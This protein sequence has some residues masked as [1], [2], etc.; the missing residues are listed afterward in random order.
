MAVSEWVRLFLY[1]IVWKFD[2]GVIPKKE[3]D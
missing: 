2:Y 1:C 3:T